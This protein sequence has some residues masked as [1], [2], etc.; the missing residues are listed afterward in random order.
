MFLGTF[1]RALHDA[2][3]TA[4]HRASDAKLKG[5]ALGICPRGDG[6]P[7]ERR[8][9]LR[10]GQR[11][12][13]RLRYGAMR[14]IWITKHG[15]P[16]VLSV[17]ESPDP[18]P[19]SGEVRVRV[20]AAGLNFADVMA[21]QGLYPD[22]PKP[23]CIVGYEGAG[24]ID[25]VGEGVTARTEGDRVLFMSRF[26]GHA[27]TVCVP[28]A[29]VF[30]MPAQMS[31]EE[32]AALPVNYV[33]AYHM[34]F[35]IRRLHHGEHV[36]IHMAAGGVGTAVLQLCRTVEGVVTY[37]TASSSKHEFIRQQG[38]SYPIDYR[39]TDFAAEVRRISGHRGVDLVLDP[40]GGPYWKKGYELLRAGGMLIAFGMSSLNAGGKRRLTRVASKVLQSPLYSP[41]KLMNDNRSV[42]G[43]NMGHLWSEI[44]MISD[45]VE[46]LAELY[47]EGNIK[48]HVSACYPFSRAAEAHGELEFG[49]NVGKIVLTPE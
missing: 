43:V 11:T 33:T 13:E 39:T 41:L 48:P 8:R 20:R 4:E 37:G 26:N 32:G 16:D 12:R 40:V 25:A 18:I 14:A 5:L 22:A 27:D 21:R 3:V 15:G 46:S 34:L 24:V 10:C 1:R 38:C 49:R 35:A 44:A 29:Q 42:A 2:A 23:P 7:C 28:E 9:T 31:F 36:L 17:R 6:M 30:G 19:G 47:D 45:E